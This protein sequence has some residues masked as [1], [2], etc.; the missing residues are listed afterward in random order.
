[1]LLT[2][3]E[4]GAERASVIEALFETQVEDGIIGSFEITEHRRPQRQPD[5]RLVAEERFKP[6]E[7]ITPARG[8]IAAA[9]GD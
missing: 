1:M 9:R 7:Q 3:M 2:A 6:V 4:A 8:L 5:Q